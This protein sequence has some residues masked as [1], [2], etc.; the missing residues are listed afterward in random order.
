MNP[1][2]PGGTYVESAS[3]RILLVWRRP[4][5]SPRGC[6]LFVPPFAEEM[7]KSR[8]ML[9]KVAI[10]L[11]EQGIATVIPDLFGTGDSAGDFGDA[12]WEAWLGD[13]RCAGQW[14]ETNLSPVS[15]LLAV[16]L[17][18]ELGADAAATGAL[19]A[20]AR[21]V[22]WQPV[23]DRSRFLTQFLRLRTAAQLTQGDHRESVEELRQQLRAGQRVEVA[24][25]TL[26]PDMARALD[27]VPA[28]A[29]LP[30]QLG[31][32]TWME[33]QRDPNAPLNPASQRLVDASIRAGS[34]VR[35]L[36]LAGE[37]FWNA[38]EIVCSPTLVD[39]TVAALA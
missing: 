23:F 24:G 8:R 4:A 39:A 20:L 9:A 15:A 26:N 37:P 21:S 16:R 31:Q 25:Y 17:G 22:F 30:L 3:G 28:R 34:N 7:N 36:A 6:V 27:Q 35:T 33:I 11:A 1:I 2:I 32:V 18:A 12:H 19:P 13:L 14:A 5:V 10:G 38:T 29:A